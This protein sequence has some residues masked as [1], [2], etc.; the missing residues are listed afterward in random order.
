[1]NEIKKDFNS[2]YYEQASNLL[3]LEV[4]NL[5]WKAVKF[6]G[7]RWCTSSTKLIRKLSSLI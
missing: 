3:G 6:T 4:G 1:M 2:F 5:M 7:Q